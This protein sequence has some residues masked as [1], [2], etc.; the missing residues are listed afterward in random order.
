MLKK[1]I[2]KQ[3]SLAKSSHLTWIKRANHLISNTS[4]NK[5]F[6]PFDSTECSLGMWI[7]QEGRKLR[8]IKKIN[9][10]IN[11]IEYHH[12]ELHNIYLNIYQIFFMIPKQKSFFQKLF[13]F[14]SEIEN[15][16][17]KDAVKLHLEDIQNS[18]ETLLKLLN[19]LENQI[20]NLT[21]TQLEGNLKTTPLVRAI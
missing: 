8:H 4:L 12:T 20:K 14:G 16:E 11:N 13:N 5:D 9:R 18:S 15:E 6:I 17:I 1:S 19:E 21:L 2:L 3:L 10:L 7:N